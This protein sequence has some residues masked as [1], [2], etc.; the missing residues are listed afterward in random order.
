MNWLFLVIGGGFLIGLIVGLCRGAVKIIVSLAATALTFVIVFFA[1]PYV[2]KGLETMT[3]LGTAIESQI[4][5]MM[6][7]VAADAVTEELEEGIEEEHIRNAL[8]AAGVSEEKLKEL[9]ITIRD[10]VE[11]RITADELAEKGISRN[12]LTGLQDEDSDVSDMLM[13]ADIPR[14]MQIAAI[15]KADIPDVF[16]N[17][18]LANNNG[19]IYEKLG[20]TTFAAYVAKYMT[21]LILN[22]LSFLLTFVVVTIILRAILFALDII[23]N[24]PVIG[25]FNRL[26]GGVLGMAGVLVVVWVVF[27]VITLLYTT[28]VGKELFV[29]IHE[30]E[31]LTF[32]YENNPIM[33]LATIWRG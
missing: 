2:S 10:I 27:V 15:E 25:F 26:G 32:L 24:L 1:T 8:S 16:K 29:M 7:K 18:L 11:G 4:L 17:L 5:K 21:K 14:E 22:V 9:G 31:F 20:V 13:G 19:E 3:P 23:S 6:S 12:I 33:K 30:N 28:G